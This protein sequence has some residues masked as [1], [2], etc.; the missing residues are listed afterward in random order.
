MTFLSV[1]AAGYLNNYLDQKYIEISLKSGRT[2]WTN[3]SKETVCDLNDVINRI[4]IK[5][6]LIKYDWFLKN[7]QLDTLGVSAGR[8]V[9]YARHRS[10]Y[11][12]AV[13]VSL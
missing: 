9:N 8:V 4:L 3:S 10:R 11:R 2:S 6:T 12:R 7:M 1:R 13:S 5:S